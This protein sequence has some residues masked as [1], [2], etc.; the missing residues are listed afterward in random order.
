MSVSAVGTPEK[1]GQNV[2]DEEESNGPNHSVRSSKLTAYENDV[3]SKKDGSNVILASGWA[4]EG[5]KEHHDMGDQRK[6]LENCLNRCCSPA[7]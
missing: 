2:W 5:E 3:K 4:I 1:M 6:T 7:L